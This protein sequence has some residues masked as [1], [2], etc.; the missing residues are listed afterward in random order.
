MN[1][2]KQ[3]VADEYRELKNR[4]NK[5]HDLLVKHDA[6]TLGFSLNCPAE[7]LKEQKAAMGKYLDILEIR[8]GMENIDL[9]TADKP[10]SRL[11]ALPPEAVE[12][13]LAVVKVTV[14]DYFC[15]NGDCQ[16]EVER[17]ENFC[18]CCGQ[19]LDW[20][21]IKPSNIGGDND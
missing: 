5:L 21:G 3:R 11:T 9:G 2:Y 18:P 17:F 13:T 14:T 4:S 16:R 15:P 1:G 6:G 8:A 7:L 19:A 20:S 10:D 12:R